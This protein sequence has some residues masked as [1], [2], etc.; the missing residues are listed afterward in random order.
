VRNAL[1]NATYFVLTKSSQSGLLLTDLN[2]KIF[3]GYR[4]FLSSCYNHITSE[5]AYPYLVIDLSSNTNRNR[6][7]KTGL[8]LNEQPIIFEPV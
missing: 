1:R 7:V 2:R 3:P 5:W 8:F 6:S 4:K